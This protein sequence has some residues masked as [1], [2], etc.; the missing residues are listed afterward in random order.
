MTN[1]KINWITGEI[2]VTN[3][4]EV[5]NPEEFFSELE[6]RNEVYMYLTE[7]GS[8]TLPDQYKDFQ[9]VFDEHSDNALPPHREG[10]DHAIKL[11]P[12]VKPTF[13]LLYNLS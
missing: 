11:L 10:L 9:D 7:E 3:N 5:F 6:T 13:S 12:G 8:L 2:D 1:P 4:I